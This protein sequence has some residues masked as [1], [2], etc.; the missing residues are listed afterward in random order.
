MGLVCST[1]KLLQKDMPD[2]P[3]DIQKCKYKFGSWNYDKT[4]IAILESDG[5]QV[6]KFVI[7]II[8]YYYY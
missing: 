2:F 6:Y 7:I 5:R 3:F 4:K 1:D 8:N